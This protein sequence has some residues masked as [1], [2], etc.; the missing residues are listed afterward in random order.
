M[1]LCAP[2]HTQLLYNDASPMENHHL[3][4][5]YAILR[6]D[7]NNFLS[8]LSRQVG[9]GAPTILAFTPTILPFA[10]NC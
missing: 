6:Q 7:R 10:L 4:G 9:A 5:A 2:S 1:S 8:T 3:A